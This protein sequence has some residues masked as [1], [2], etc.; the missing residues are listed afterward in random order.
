M[1]P[2]G[3]A[4]LYELDAVAPYADSTDAVSCTG[5]ALVA[6]QCLVRMRAFQFK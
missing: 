5:H 3:K 2:W 1:V 4:G 6:V